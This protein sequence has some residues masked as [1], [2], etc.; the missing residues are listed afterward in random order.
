MKKIKDI[1]KAKKIAKKR[2]VHEQK[3]AVKRA[4]L[5]KNYSGKVKGISSSSFKKLLKEALKAD[6]TQ[7]KQKTQGKATTKRSFLDRINPF[8]KNK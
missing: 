3:R 2:T 4:N 5:K 7:K 6:K 1:E 8:S